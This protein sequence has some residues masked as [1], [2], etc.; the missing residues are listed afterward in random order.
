MRLEQKYNYTQIQLLLLPQMCIDQTQS[1]SFKI[2]NM[3]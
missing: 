2:A 3:L 1:P